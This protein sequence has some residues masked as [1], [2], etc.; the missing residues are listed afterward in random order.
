MAP[1]MA[2]S[3]GIALMLMGMAVLAV[4]ALVVAIVLRCASC[5][6]RAMVR[7]LAPG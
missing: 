6:E 3:V 2:L 7:P 1:V 4:V 5:V